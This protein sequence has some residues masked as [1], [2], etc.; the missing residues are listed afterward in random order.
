MVR[1]SKK[2]C[3]RWGLLLLDGERGGALGRS[4]VAADVTYTKI[5]GQTWKKSQSI[6]KPWNEI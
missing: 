4:S 3:W 2:L 6:S 1:T 5:W